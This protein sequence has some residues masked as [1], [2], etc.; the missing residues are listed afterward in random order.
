MNNIN[1]KQAT[2]LLTI[3][4]WARKQEQRETSTQKGLVPTWNEQDEL[5][6]FLWKIAVDKRAFKNGEKGYQGKKLNEHGLR[7]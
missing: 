2:T 6:E 5:I 3:L 4:E 7:R 1:K